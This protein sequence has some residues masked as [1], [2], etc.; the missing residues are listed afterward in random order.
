MARDT[1]LYRLKTSDCS[2]ETFGVTFQVTILER[3][4]YKHVDKSPRIE[5]VHDF[6]VDV[7]WIVSWYVEKS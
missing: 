7:R 5:H 3:N 2:R 6:S 4:V 1:A